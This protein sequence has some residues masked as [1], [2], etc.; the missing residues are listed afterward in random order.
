MTKPESYVSIATFDRASLWERT[1]PL[2]GRIDLE[3]TERCNN[4]CVHCCINLPE[5]DEA[6]RKMELST[7]GWKK[8]LQEVADLG[9]L[10][11]RFT[12]GEPLLREDFKE[13][14]LFTRK[15]GIR[16]MLFTNARL[17][18][19]ELAELLAAYPP[20]EVVEV[21]VYGMHQKSYEAV[22]RTPGSFEEFWRGLS[23]LLEKKIPFIIKGALLPQNK[24]EIEEFEAFAKT[25]PYLDHAP[26]YSMFFDLRCRRDDPRKNRLIAKNRLSPEEGLK[27]LTRDKEKYIKGMKEFCS[28]FMRPPGKKLFSC[29]AGHGGGCVDAYGSLQLC[30]MLTHPAAV[31]SLKKGSIKDAFQNFFPKIQQQKAD[32]PEYLKRCAKCF[33]KG[34]CEQCPAKSW[35]ENGDLDTPVEYACRVAHV[36]AEYLGLIGKGEKAWEVGEWEARIDRIGIAL[37]G[38]LCL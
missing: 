8:I 19:P 25:I 31:Y 14:Y 21:T 26:S 23:L 16:V 10:T 11:V 1:K 7:D 35:I 34:L 38:R 37:L 18:T 3:L 9:G 22:S 20:R 17:I 29:G 5:N 4:N 30:M 12:G 6:S 33:L 13:L 24:H 15:L 28:K 2:I 27:I 36:Q 32:N